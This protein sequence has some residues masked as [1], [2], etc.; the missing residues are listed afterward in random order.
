VSMV[1]NYRSQFGSSVRQNGIT[2]LLKE[3]KEKNN[4]A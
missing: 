1:T 2:G 3:L 4:A